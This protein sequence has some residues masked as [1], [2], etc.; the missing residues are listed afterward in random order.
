MKDIILTLIVGIVMGGAFSIMK[1]PIP[2]PQTIAGVCGVI[3]IFLG[4]FLVRM[5][6]K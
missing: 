2:A 3:G 4:Y 1:L 6:M 5:V